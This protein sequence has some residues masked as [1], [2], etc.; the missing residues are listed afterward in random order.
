MPKRSLAYYLGFKICITL[1]DIVYIMI[2]T[3]HI[4]ITI[5]SAT[6]TDIFGVLTIYIIASFLILC[7]A[8]LSFSLLKYQKTEKQDISF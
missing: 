1:A 5:K 6:I 4:Y 2:I 7:S 3:T 8:C